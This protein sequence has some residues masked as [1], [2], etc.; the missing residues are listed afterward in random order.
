[1]ATSFVDLVDLQD[2]IDYKTWKFN[3][4]HSF[5]F[6]KKKLRLEVRKIIQV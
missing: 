4:M 2:K 6:I 5:I 1:M 3:K